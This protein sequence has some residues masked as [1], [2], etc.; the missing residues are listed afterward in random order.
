L[1][2]ER[3][4]LEQEAKED[5]YIAKNIVHRKTLSVKLDPKDPSI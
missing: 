1:E 4:Q 3:R 5:A 2:K